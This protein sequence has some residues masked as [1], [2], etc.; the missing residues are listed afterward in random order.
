V[1]YF[2]VLTTVAMTIGLIVGYAIRPGAGMVL[3]LAVN[4]FM[5]EARAITNLYAN[6]VATIFVVCWE[7]SL[8][9]E[10]AG[11]VLAEATSA[12]EVAA[13]AG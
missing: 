4:R 8:D 7:G 12:G 13:A 1:V 11:L 9:R 5:G 6:A 2:E 3:L 10:K